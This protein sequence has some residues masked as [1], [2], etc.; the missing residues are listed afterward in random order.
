ML[1]GGCGLGGAWHCGQRRCGAAACATWQKAEASAVLLPLPIPFTAPLDLL[2]PPPPIHPPKPY[3]PPTHT[4]KKKNTKKTPNPNP[5]PNTPCLS[6]YVQAG[7]G[8]EGRAAQLLVR[9]RDSVTFLHS[10]DAD[11]LEPMLG[12]AEQLGLRVRQAG[13]GG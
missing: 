1:R 10:I 2:H 8:F 7:Q 3:P 11:E 12:A 6:R 9:G 5:N 4:H 13:V